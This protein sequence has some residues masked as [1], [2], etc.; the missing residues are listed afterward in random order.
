MYTNEEHIYIY[1]KMCDLDNLL[2]AKLNVF[3]TVYT[4]E[5]L[6]FHEMVNLFLFIV[7]CYPD[8]EPNLS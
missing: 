3:Y 8:P 1:K 4:S 7:Y 6:H 2:E 5:F